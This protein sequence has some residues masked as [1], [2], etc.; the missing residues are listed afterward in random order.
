MKTKQLLFAMAAIILLSVTACKKYPEGPA[1]SLRS[2]A[3]RVANNW[4]VSQAME[5]GADVTTDYNRYELD[6]TKDGHAS[7]SAK[8]KFLGVDYE[9]VTNGNWTF[10]S[11]KEKISFDFDNNSADGVYEILKLKEEEMWLK[12]DGKSLE[13]HFVPR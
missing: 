2:K 5:N 10:T 6:L 3:E 8:Y 7:L 1:I 13:L 4:K 12:E 9:Y 11:S